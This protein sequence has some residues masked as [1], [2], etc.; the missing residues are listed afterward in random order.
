MSITCPKCGSR[1]LRP[2][3]VRNASE[4]LARLRLVYPLRCMDCQARFSVRTFVW[5]DLFFARCPRCRRM[6]LNTWSGRTY[7]N[8]PFQV[9]LKIALGAKRWRCEYCRLN[10]ASFRKRKE[11]FTFQRWKRFVPSGEEPPEAK[12]N[13]PAGEEAKSRGFTS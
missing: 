9:T 11:I 10:F 3:R 7:T 13:A 12:A 6:D 8:P 4:A 5:K 1:Y 2:S